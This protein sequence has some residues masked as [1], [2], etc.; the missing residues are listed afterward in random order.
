MIAS[1]ALAMT[2]AAPAPATAA[3]NFT[4]ATAKGGEISLSQF[5]DKYVVLE[6]WNKDCPFVVRHYRSKNMQGLQEK[7]TKDGVVWITIN[8][9][10]AGKQGHVN[11]TQAWDA[12]KSVG[13]KPTHIVL[14]HD[15]AIGKK[16]EA[17]TTPQMV[18]IAP[19]TQEKLYDGAIDDA[20]RGNA[21]VNY[22]TQAYSE[23][24]AGKPVSVK[25]K[26]PYG[27]SVKY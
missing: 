5:K 13:G 18:L 11:A 21:T 27:C 6:W 3:Y 15:G 12:M 19:N 24:K 20:P 25:S 8:S 17:K 1:I 22:L 10:A 7:M 26:R 23:A 2:I 9:S 4:G 14:D 16:Y